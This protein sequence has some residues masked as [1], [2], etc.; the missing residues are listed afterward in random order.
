MCKE[1]ILKLR[2]SMIIEAAWLY[3]TMPNS[4]GPKDRMVDAVTVVWNRSIGRA[5]FGDFEELSIGEEDVI[6]AAKQFNSKDKTV[7][8]IKESN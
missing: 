2:E 6:E 7:F 3:S 1:S 5:G 4:Q 8:V